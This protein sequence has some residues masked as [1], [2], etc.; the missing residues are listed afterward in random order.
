MKRILFVLKE[1]FYSYSKI[2][3]GL[4]NSS[5]HL[6]EYLEYE[7]Y[8]CKVVTVVDANGI[9]KEIHKFKPDVVVIEALWVPTYKLK[10]LIEIHRY[11]HIK[12]VVRIHSD[13]GFLSAENNALK[14]LNEYAELDKHNL[15]ISLNNQGFIFALSSV[16]KHKLVYLPNIIMHDSEVKEPME[17]KDHIDIGCFGA[18]RLLKNQVFQAICSIKAADILDM[19]LKFHVTPNLDQKIADPILR[20]L[21]QL[22]KNSKHELVIHDW[23]PNPEF[24][25]LVKRM[26]VGL[27][28][29][30][31]ESFNIISTDFINNDRIIL[32]SEA[33][34]WLPDRLKAST[35]DYT[36]CTNK[37]VYAYKNRDN[38]RVKRLAKR[39]L[40]KY[41]IKA[42]TEWLKFLNDTFHHDHDN[43]HHRR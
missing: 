22:F 21:I 4:I 1:R 11:M 32:G 27:Q 12:W 35:V 30:Y 37:I 34:E 16:I 9:D 36:E 40:A 8:E 6:A 39:Y 15:V 43:D 42:K 19:K 25:E 7:G 28:V 13:I 29:S 5:V 17:V 20:N 2:S 26:D 23:L 38:K 10:E 3:Y 33:I 18:T 24:Q 41:N 14:Y 31:T